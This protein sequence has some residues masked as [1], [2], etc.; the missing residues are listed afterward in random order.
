[1]VLAIRLPFVPYDPCHVAVLYR[2]D[3]GMQMHALA[4]TYTLCAA[5]HLDA[6][7]MSAWLRMKQAA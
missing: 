2:A 5:S 3:V 1:M 7:Q 4:P 6:Q